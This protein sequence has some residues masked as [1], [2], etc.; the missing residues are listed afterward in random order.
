MCG[1]GALKVSICSTERFVLYNYDPFD[2]I[3]RCQIITYK[4]PRCLLIIPESS[5][6]LFI[7]L[8]QNEA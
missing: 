2:S 6:K 1:F 5:L 3:Q 7:L 4:C 8:Q